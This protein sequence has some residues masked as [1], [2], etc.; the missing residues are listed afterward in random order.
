MV[1][2]YVDGRQRKEAV[3]TLDEARRLKARREAD[4]EHGEFHA[5][6]RATLREYALGWVERYQGRGR[7]GFRDSTRDDYRQ[8][9]REIE[10]AH[11]DPRCAGS[12]GQVAGLGS[13]RVSESVLGRIQKLGEEAVRLTCALAILGDRAWLSDAAALAE[14]DEEQAIRAAAALVDA[15]VL[16]EGFPLE[17]AH[18]LVRSA[19]YEH[20]PYAER[21]SAHERAAWILAKSGARAEVAA[22]HLL[23]TPARSDLWGV[24]L[25]RRAA[26]DAARQGSPN[27]AITYLRRALAEP[28][29]E[30][31]KAGILAELGISEHNAE[32][33]AAIEHLSGAL[34]LTEEPS[35]RARVGLILARAI[36]H[37]GQIL[38]AVALLEGLVDELDERLGERLEAELIAIARLNPKRGELDL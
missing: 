21:L 25:L 18:P 30:S 14:L 15:D 32:D 35:E 23:I 12:A 20:L 8:L 2:F 38:D 37:Q 33:Q 7:R 16:S 11:I 13:R 24:D 9:L 34:E 28:L 5:R 27:D 6:S 3:R 17:F 26:A 31:A 4:V 29:P 1:V 10:A 22:A 36:W 19:I